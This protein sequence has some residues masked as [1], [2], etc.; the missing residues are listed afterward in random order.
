MEVQRDD[1]IDQAIGHF[2]ALRRLRDAMRDYPSDAGLR[3]SARY[4]L[5]R[6]ATLA[7]A[8]CGRVG[9]GTP[10]LAAAG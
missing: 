4:H 6:A 10:A 7:K 2:M 3:Q 8:H 9:A 1:R 5:A